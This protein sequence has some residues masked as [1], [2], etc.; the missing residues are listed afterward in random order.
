[1]RP[2]AHRATSMTC[3]TS[4]V[5]SISVMSRTC[6]AAT[7]MCLPHL[8]VTSGTSLR[9]SLLRPEPVPLGPVRAVTA[10]HPGI[11]LSR[12]APLAGC[13]RF[14]PLL[15]PLPPLLP[16]LLLPFQRVDRRGR[17]GVCIVFQEP[18]E[19]LDGPVPLTYRGAQ[20]LDLGDEARDPL[21]RAQQCPS[22]SLLTSFAPFTRAGSGRSYK[23]HMSIFLDLGRAGEFIPPK[24]LKH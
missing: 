24:I 6:L 13:A 23:D 1:M 21:R 5:T 19:P 20:L 12:A 4:A 8:H 16:L 9:P 17:V 22:C 15:A 10:R 11:P 2:H 7:S 14:P 18:F 3:R